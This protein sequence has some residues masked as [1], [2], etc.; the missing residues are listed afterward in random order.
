MQFGLAYKL[1]RGTVDSAFWKVK[2][3]LLEGNLIEMQVISNK[4][5]HPSLTF[6]LPVVKSF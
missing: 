5:T 2:V 4:V 6:L 3:S 1:Q